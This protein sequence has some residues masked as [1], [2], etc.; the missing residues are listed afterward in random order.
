MSEDNIIAY[1]NNERNEKRLL[2]GCGTVYYTVPQISGIYKSELRGF[3]NLS[4]G[5]C[6]SQ[7]DPRGDESADQ[8]CS[9]YITF[10]QRGRFC[11]Q[12]WGFI[13]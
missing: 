11:P 1:E 5:I 3:A 7:S 12:N 10:P 4:F 13:S 6:K 9:H 2:L 8:L